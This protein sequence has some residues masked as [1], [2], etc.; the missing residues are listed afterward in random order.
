M[1]R[2]E[3]NKRDGSDREELSEQG[4][5]RDEMRL[6]RLGDIAFCLVAG[7]LNRIIRAVSREERGGGGTVTTGGK[8]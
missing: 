8:G 1:E 4:K 6:G 5:G 3:E 7:S 2:K